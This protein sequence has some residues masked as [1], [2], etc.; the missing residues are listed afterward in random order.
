LEEKLT[1]AQGNVISSGFK[2][3]N[4]T[5]TNLGISPNVY[6]DINNYYQIQLPTHYAGA[7]TD[8]LGYAL[9]YL[10]AFAGSIDNFVDLFGGSGSASVAVT[11]HPAFTDYYIN[12]LDFFCVNYYLVISDEQ[13]YA[14]YKNE[15]K[16]IQDNLRKNLSVTDGKKF[17]QIVRKNEMHGI[18]SIRYK[19]DTLYKILHINFRLIVYYG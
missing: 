17:F 9:N 8:Y 11:Q 6:Y 7:K 15:L 16:K 18:R 2:F 14:M 3:T 19:M 10:V 4:K 5:F 13:L 12:E 1:D